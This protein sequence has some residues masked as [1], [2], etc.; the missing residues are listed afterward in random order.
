[1]GT[2]NSGQ[3]SRIL[4][5]LTDCRKRAL[6]GLAGLHVTSKKAQHPAPAHSNYWL[7][8][9]DS[10]PRHKFLAC[11]HKL[12]T[13]RIKIMFPAR[14]AKQ[15]FRPSNDAAH[16]CPLLYP[17]CSEVARD[18]TCSPKKRAL[19]VFLVKVIPPASCRWVTPY[20]D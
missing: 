15:T 3:S 14:T 8:S 17:V 9:Y 1:M 12:L 16:I 7:H 11:S 5:R 20:R 13:I 10:S 6:T 18:D 2:R 19:P 4:I